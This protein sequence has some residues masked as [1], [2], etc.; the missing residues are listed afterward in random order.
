MSKKSAYTQFLSL[1]LG[2]SLMTAMISCTDESF[3]PTKNK[4]SNQVE[5][6]QIEGRYQVTFLPLNSSVSGITSGS[7]KIRIIANKIA[8]S[9][10]ITD[11]PAKAIHSQFIYT[12]SECP[13]ELH[14]I[15]KDGFIDQ[16]E[17]AK[18]LGSILIPLDGDLNFQEQGEAHFP[19]S[20]SLGNYSYYQEAEFSNMLADLNAPDLN[21]QDEIVKLI[22]GHD[23][24]LQG[25]V[26]VIE[27]VSQD[28]YLPGSIQSIGSNSDRKSLPIAC[29]VIH[30][31]ILED[32][33]T[34]E[35]VEDI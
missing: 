11:S 20:D 33:E 4:T 21:L 27:G 13:T 12:A 25:K 1:V 9:V 30:R 8:V 34:T 10:E 15:N 17:A 3:H 19:W 26:I 14:D 29:G 5:E 22:P 23:L 35:G 24:K 28:D 7:A 6:P 32:S 2:A 16:V 31:A 18:V